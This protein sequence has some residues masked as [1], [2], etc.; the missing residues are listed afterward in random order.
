MQNLIELVT[1]HRLA[2]RLNVDDAAL[3]RGLAKGKFV[4]DA[5]AGK[6]LLVKAEREAEIGRAVGSPA[7]PL[8]AVC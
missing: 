6:I 3:R 2:R 5:I 4:P 7:Y 8:E 1:L